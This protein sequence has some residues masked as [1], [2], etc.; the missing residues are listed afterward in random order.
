MTLEERVEVLE[1]DAAQKKAAEFMVIEGQ[2]IKV[3]KT[4]GV[5]VFRLRSF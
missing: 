2:E 3:I 4:E 1:K 5:T